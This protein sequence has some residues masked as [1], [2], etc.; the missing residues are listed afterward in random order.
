MRPHPVRSYAILV[1]KNLVSLYIPS[2]ADIPSIYKVDVFFCG[3]NDLKAD[4]YYLI[5]P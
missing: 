4:L 2:L 3:W 1:S 5:L